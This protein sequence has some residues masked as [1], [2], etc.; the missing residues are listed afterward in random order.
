MA[1][2]AYASGEGQSCWQSIVEFC[3]KSGIQFSVSSSV[4]NEAGSW[5]NTGNAVDLVSSAG[6][7]QQLAKWLQDNYT[8]Y[9]LELIHSAGPG[10]FVKDGKRVDAAFYGAAT[11]SEHYNHVHV[12]M[13]SSGIAAANVGGAAGAA[14]ADAAVDVSKPQNTNGCV[15]PAMIGVMIVGAATSGAGWMVWEGVRWLS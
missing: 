12:A 3:R 11:V 6:S 5:H 7:M 1:N 13:T 8:P 10:Y 9:L 15:I 4:R 2:F 14:V